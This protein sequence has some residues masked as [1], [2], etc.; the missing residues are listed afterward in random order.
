V[1]FISFPPQLLSF[2]PYYILET[3]FFAYTLRGPRCSAHKLNVYLTV[4]FR[5]DMTVILKYHYYYDCYILIIIIIAIITYLILLLLL[6]LHTYYYYYILTIITIVTIV[7]LVIIA[8]VLFFSVDHALTRAVALAAARA[9]PAVVAVEVGARAA[10][11]ARPERAVQRATHV[12]RLGTAQR[13][14][15]RAVHAAPRSGT[16]EERETKRAVLA[17]L[18]RRHVTVAP[19]VTPE[20]VRLYPL[21]A[22]SL[23]ITSG[24]EILDPCFHERLFMARIYLRIRMS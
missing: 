4:A 13:M 23:S 12:A 6:L 7:V 1:E 21:N 11:A 17:A 9:A 15:A 3:V 10:H 5:C 22:G 24:S 18:S 2:I 14:R 19:R 8:R 20:V 16:R